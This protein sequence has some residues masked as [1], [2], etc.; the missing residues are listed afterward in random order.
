MIALGGW[1]DATD[2]RACSRIRPAGVGVRRPWPAVSPCP[3]GVRLNL[4][5]LFEFRA[6]LGEDLRAEQLDALEE[7]G[8]GHAAGVHLQDLAGVAE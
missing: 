1:C 8:V 7:G 4:P 3:L 5:P 2:A 6:D